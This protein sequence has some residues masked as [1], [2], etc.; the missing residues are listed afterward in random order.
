MVTGRKRAISDDDVPVRPVPLAGV[1]FILLTGLFVGYL[2][3]Q[4]DTRT[5]TLDLF[6]STLQLGENESEDHD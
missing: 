1:A 4:Y 3:Q 2:A 5:R 6:G